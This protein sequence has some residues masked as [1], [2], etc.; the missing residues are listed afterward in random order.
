MVRLATARKARESDFAAAMSPASSA[1]AGAMQQAT[2]S[3]R[4]IRTELDRLGIG[5]EREFN[6]ALSIRVRVACRAYFTVWPKY[7][8][9]NLLR[10]PEKETE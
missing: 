4:P 10:S 7:G 6:M 8:E 9:R 2:M 1:L 5:R 3:N